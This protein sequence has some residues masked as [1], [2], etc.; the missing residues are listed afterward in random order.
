MLVL[1]LVLEMIGLT[2]TTRE[3]GVFRCLTDGPT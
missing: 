2:K 3:I 1:D